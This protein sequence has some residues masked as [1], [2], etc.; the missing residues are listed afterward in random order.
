MNFKD[1]QYSIGKFKADVHSQI[2]KKNPLQKQDTKAL[3]TWISQERYDLASMKTV[4]Y[5]RSETVKAL[6]DWI[7][8]EAAEEKSENAQDLE[9]IVGN[10]LCYLLDKQIEIEQE[11]AGRK[12]KWRG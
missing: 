3:S 10:K 1:L 12:K 11:F 9:D 6:K 5:E 7:K 8:E 2:A 4:A